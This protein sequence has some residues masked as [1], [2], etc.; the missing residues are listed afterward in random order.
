MATGRTYGDAARST[1][2]S[3]VGMAREAVRCSYAR[4]SMGR[5]VGRPTRDSS[6]I[7][8]E[9]SRSSLRSLVVF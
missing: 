5:C 9:P 6:S 1:G 7:K 4:S 2:C 8:T 3:N